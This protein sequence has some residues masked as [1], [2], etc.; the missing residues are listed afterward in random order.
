MI[1]KISKEIKKIRNKKDALIELLNRIISLLFIILLYILSLVIFYLFG[2]EIENK[3]LYHILAI[4]FIAVTTLNTFNKRVVQIIL[5][6]IG[7][8]F[9][10]IIITQVLLLSYVIAPFFGA[11]LI[12]NVIDAKAYSLTGIV[13]YFALFIIVST[14]L[15]GCFVLF[16]RKKPQFIFS[17]FKEIGL[18]DLTFVEEFYDR[19]ID[20]LIR[21]LYLVIL[22]FSGTL[23]FIISFV[24]LFFEL[25]NANEESLSFKNKPTFFAI[26]TILLQVVFHG[27]IAGVTSKIKK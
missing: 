2:V 7:K 27:Q 20:N 8:V 16:L 17:T 26:L 14:T 18:I 5:G 21:I 9:V 19:Y 11:F 6:F 1:P 25:S 13:V 4:I 3:L 12:D 15:S 10:A 22:I 24:P 23:T